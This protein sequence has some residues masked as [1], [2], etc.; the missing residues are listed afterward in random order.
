MS[1]IPNLSA[2]EQSFI[3]DRQN[4]RKFAKWVITMYNPLFE[5][6]RDLKFGEISDEEYPDNSIDLSDK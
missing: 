2:D 4:C 6:F 5:K 1:N 3:N